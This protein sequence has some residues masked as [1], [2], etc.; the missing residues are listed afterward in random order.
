MWI[1]SASTPTTALSHRFG[2]RSLE[3]LKITMQ[4]IVA[5]IAL[6]IMEIVLGIDNIVFISIATGKLPK[7]QQALARNV[8]LGLAM[9]MRILLLLFISWIVGL[10]A[11]LFTWEGLGI[12]VQSIGELWHAENAPTHT[13]ELNQ[14]SARDLILLL[15]G[16]YLLWSSVWEIHHKVT[17]LHEG[18]P[19]AGGA[20]FRAT[21]AQIVVLDVV[22]SLDSVLTAIG[23]A[24]DI[25]VMVTAV[26]LAVGVMLAF[27]GA[28]SSFVEK[29]PTVKIL[30]LSFLLLIGVMLVSEG[31]GTHIEKGYVYFSMFFALAV[32]GLILRMQYNAKQRQLAKAAA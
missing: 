17:G 19:E 32:E 4:A 18:T 3:E 1:T 15:G 28:V 21:V 6:T 11:P 27:S 29:H 23:M 10:K 8:G 24:K 16:L 31:L 9:G 5:L 2:P 13:E 26:V 12:P 7:E 14:V 22:F 30:A 20:N 25:W